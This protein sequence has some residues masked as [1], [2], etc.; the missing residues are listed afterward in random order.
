MRYHV[1]WSTYGSWLPGDPRDFRT[2]HHRMHVEGDYRNPPPPG[3]H[4]GLRRHARQAMGG[5]PVVIPRRL[6]P[7]AGEAALER[8]AIEGAVILALSLAGQHVHVAFLGDSGDV[9]PAI[10]R[11]KKVS[12][13]RI[14]QELPG[15]VWAGGCKVVRVREDAHWRNVLTY[16]GNHAREGAWVWMKEER[17]V[18]P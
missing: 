1:I 11:V 8:L 4:A 10:G 18:S 13:H 15:Q 2:R 9:K 17:V 16:L 14:R 3:T 5:D 12:S 6:R 7:V